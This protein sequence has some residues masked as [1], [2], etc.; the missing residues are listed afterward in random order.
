MPASIKL[1][2]LRADKF[3]SDQLECAALD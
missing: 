1:I 2:S 3:R